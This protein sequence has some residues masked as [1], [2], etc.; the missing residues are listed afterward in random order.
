MRARR[1]TYE[2]QCAAI[3]RSTSQ[4]NPWDWARFEV[5]AQRWADLS[6]TGYGVSIL[7]DC[8]HGY[9]ARSNTMRLSLLRSPECPDPEADQGRHEFT[10]S[11]YPHRG[12]WQAG[13]TV[14]EAIELNTSVL[15]ARVGSSPGELAREGSFLCVEAA[16]GL[17]VVLSALKR[18]EDG[19][20]FVARVYEPAGRRTRVT[21]DAMCPIR[22]AERVNLIED[23][24]GKMRAGKN[25]L[26]FDLAPWQIASVR[27]RFRR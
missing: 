5:P 23:S 25:G 13:G 8:K 20:G 9:D 26:T 17:G 2:I 21:L 18:A 7:N 22:S 3:D 11:I 6:E 12:S 27:L 15:C 14:E 10:Y 4:S 19:D 24:K 1:A 16:D